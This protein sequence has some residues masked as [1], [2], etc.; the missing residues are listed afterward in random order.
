MIVFIYD[1][2]I[3]SRSETDH[4]SHLRIVLKALKD[5]QLFAKF[6]KCEFLLR[7]IAFLAHIISCK[8]VDFNPKKTKVVK[9][10]PRPL[11]PTQHIKFSRVGRLL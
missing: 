1:I 4:M 5:N 2:L 3:Y 6:N 10:L 9:R 11:S 7:S 8:G